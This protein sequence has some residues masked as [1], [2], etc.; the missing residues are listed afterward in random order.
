MILDMVVL[1]VLTAYEDDNNN[2]IVYDG[3]DIPGVRIEFTGRSNTLT[4]GSEPRVNRLTIMFDCDNGVMTMQG[5]RFGSFSGFIRIGQDSTVRLGQNVTT[6]NTCVI[7]A[8]EGTSVTIGHDVMLASENEI[9]ADDGHAIFD[10]HSDQRV[11][12]SADITVGNHVWLAK[13]AVLLGGASIGDGSVIGFGSL[14]SGPIPNNCVAV[15]SPARVVRRDVAWERPHLS[16]ARPYYKPDGSTVAKS[17]YWHPTSTE[18]E[19]TKF[20]A[21]GESKGRSFAVLFTSEKAAQ[22][23]AAQN[24]VPTKVYPLIDRQAAEELRSATI[25]DSP[26]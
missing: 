21:V 3:P 23:W 10:I 16:R 12:K 9:R 5:S 7:S 13:R 11:N 18:A 17:A 14:V 6:T 20:A 8:V 4:V 24:T 25:S 22:A 1:N 19:A 15:G 26:V 2:R